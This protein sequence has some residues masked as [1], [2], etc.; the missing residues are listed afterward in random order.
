QLFGTGSAAGNIF[1][2]LSL[3][4]VAGLIAAAL[5]SRTRNR[6]VSW[7]ILFFLVMMLPTSNLVITIGSIM[8]ERF[9]YLPSIGFC[10][11]AAVLIFALSGKLQSFTQTSE[12]SRPVL[13]WTLPVVV[14][15]L[16]G[17]R[18]VVR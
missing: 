13:Q 5:Y 4:A 16:L 9:L 12:R 17:V 1:V 7:G 2:W 18:T 10:A 15:A 6:M 14:I 8:A 3:A 11:A